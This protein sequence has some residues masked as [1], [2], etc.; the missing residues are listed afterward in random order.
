MIK[1]T[2]ILLLL[3]TLAGCSKKMM[4]PAETKIKII[5]SIVEREKTVY[6]DTTIVLP[7]DTT[8]IYF[9]IPCPDVVVNE[10]V[11]KGNMHLTAKSDGKGNVKINCSSDSLKLVIKGLETIIKEKE[12]YHANTTVQKIPYPVEVIKYKKPKSWWWLLL[13]VCGETFWIFRKPILG[14]IK[15]LFGLWI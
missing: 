8:E 5:D 6:R 14:L 3:I 11:S 2:T 13:I 4:P 9:A 1:L 12:K 15:K 10:K 7:G